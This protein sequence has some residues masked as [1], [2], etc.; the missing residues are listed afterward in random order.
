MSWLRPH[1]RSYAYVLVIACLAGCRGPAGGRLEVTIQGIDDQASGEVSGG[2]FDPTHLR[3]ILEKSINDSRRLHLKDQD[4]PHIYRLELLVNEVIERD[5]LNAEKPGVYRSVQVGLVL[6][7][8]KDEHEREQLASKGKSSQ[9][10]DS[11]KLEPEEGFGLL[12]EQA[13]RNAV[14][15]IELQIDTRDLPLM[16]LRDL[17]ESEQSERRLYVLRALRERSADELMPQVLKLLNDSDP[18]IILEAIGVLVAHKEQRAVTPLIRLVEGKDQVFLLQVITALSEIG[19]P[20]ARGYL[21]TVSS[22]YTSPLIRERATEA[23]HQLL[24]SEQPQQTPKASPKA[25]VVPQQPMGHQEEHGR[26]DHEL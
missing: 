14:E 17:L 11:R 25:A 4:E 22:G 2:R 24:Q 19:G 18:E 10:Q 15:N 26:G 20:V 6:T 12:L 8:W 5:S 13:V 23:L 7:R 21:F 16:R 1:W 9:V 3:N